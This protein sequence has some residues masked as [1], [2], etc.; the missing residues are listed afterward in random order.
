[1]GF[2]R[3]ELGDLLISIEQNHL[4]P[5]APDLPS[6]RSPET[7]R[8]FS[9]GAIDVIVDATS[10]T[11]LDYARDAMSRSADVVDS[12][13]VSGQGPLAVFVHAVGPDS[14]APSSSLLAFR[15]PALPALPSRR[16]TKV[17]PPTPEY[18]TCEKETFS[19][20][21]CIE[22]A[23]SAYE[24]ELKD[25]VAAEKEAQADYER[26]LA[27]FE[28]ELATARSGVKQATDRLRALE[29]KST[30]VASDI[31]GAFL[32]AGQNLTS[33]GADFKLLLAQTD[34]IPFGR[35]STG[36]LRLE[37]VH[38]RLMDW[39]ARD[40][41]AAE[42]L[43]DLWEGRFRDAGAASVRFLSPALTAVADLLEGV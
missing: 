14:F 32:V 1:M 8:R 36:E 39:D 4:V 3:F 43:R 35:Q 20:Q 17:R 31:S 21:R 10:S 42:G 15:I 24:T 19:K 22:Q 12:L 18:G 13:A 7:G 25:V 40:A 38:V 16:E 37:G 34:L 2:S 9:A 6:E 11:I 5:T 41:V 28:A 26:R 33:I 23:N 27:A 29:T 30:N